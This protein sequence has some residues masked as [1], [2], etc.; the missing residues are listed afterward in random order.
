MVVPKRDRLREFY[1]RLMAAPAAATFDE[2]LDQVTTIL[3]AVEDELTGIPNDP[4]N[5][6]HDERIYP[7]QQDNLRPVAAH[8]Q[9]ARFRSVRH[10]TYIGTNGAVEIASTDGTVELRKPG[11]DG[12]GVWELDGSDPVRGRDV[13]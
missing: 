10:S 7:P 5:W 4:A 8:P 1:R 12:R 9:V 3:D 13:R 6:R 2:A 11:M